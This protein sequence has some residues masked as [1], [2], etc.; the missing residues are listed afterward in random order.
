[1]RGMGDVQRVQL[2]FGPGA[3]AVITKALV[4]VLE[5]FTV[6]TPAPSE[7]GEAEP[8]AWAPRVEPWAIYGPREKE[9]LVAFLDG[10]NQVRHVP[11]SRSTEAPKG[12]RRIYLEVADA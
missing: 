10:D 9:T 2:T 1:M 12:W 11:L 6:V 4:E 5:H 7:G 3:G 8:A